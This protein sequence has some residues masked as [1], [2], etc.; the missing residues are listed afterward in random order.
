MPGTFAALYNG[1]PDLK[2]KDSTDQKL[3]GLNDY[4]YQLV[5][6]LG[7]ALTNL[8]EGN[9]NVK[10]LQE[11]T[12]PIHAEIEDVEAGLTTKIDVAAGKIVLE[13]TSDL[14]P[15]WAVSTT[16]KVNDV[17]KIVTMTDG[18]ITDV[19][20]YKC[21]AAHTSTNNNKP[22]TSGGGAYWTEIPASGVANS[23]IT[24]TADNIMLQVRGDYVKEWVSG[25]I[26][27][28]NDVVKITASDDTFTCYRCIV[29]HP[30]NNS[31]RPGSGSIWEQRWVAIDNP[32]DVQSAID[33]NLKGLTLSYDPAQSGTNAPYITLNKDGTTIGGGPV[34]IDELD[35]ST[36]KTGT[37]D[38]SRINLQNRFTVY[39]SLPNGGNIACGDIGGSAIETGS[40][41]YKGSIRIQTDLVDHRQSLYY[42]RNDMIYMDSDYHDSDNDIW[43]YAT[44]NI[45]PTGIV[46]MRRLNGPPKSF[47]LFDLEARVTA[48]E[49]A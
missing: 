37:L 48:L 7:Y 18:E 15:A 12:D 39:A 1:F 16:Y 4:L 40:G 41:N 20:Y 14:A 32:P 19:K 38:A 17:V 44:M 22:G 33:L 27:Y 2:G 34:H 30:A 5:E 10:G 8:D 36:I 3:A 29:Q 23:R 6:R 45:T 28:V 9:F 13:V 11:I 49:N 43:N 31:N 42:L 35:A 25:T 21:T 47:D 26:Y 24:Q 46:V